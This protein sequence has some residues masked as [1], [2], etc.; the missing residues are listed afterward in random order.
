MEFIW[1]PKFETGYHNEKGIFAH[2][3]LGHYNPPG[4]QFTLGNSWPSL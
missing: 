1:K 3:L 4:F 2:K